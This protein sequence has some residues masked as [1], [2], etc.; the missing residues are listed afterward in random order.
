V[1]AIRSALL[2][3][4]PLLAGLCRLDLLLADA[5]AVPAFAF[6]AFDSPVLPLAV[7]VLLEVDVFFLLDVECLAAG[8]WSS[9]VCP[10]TG[11]AIIEQ[12][13]AAATHRVASEARGCWRE[14]A[15]IISLYLY[16]CLLDA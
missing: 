3:R 14:V 2:A 9:E 16:L 7:F 6:A 4:L 1:R 10:A 8:F 13:S 11:N 12:A 5:L 15:L